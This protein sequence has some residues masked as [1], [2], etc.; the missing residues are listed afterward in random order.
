[1][2]PAL[3]LV[4][5]QP[6]PVVCNPSMPFSTTNLRKWFA[7]AA[8]VIVLTIIVFYISARMQVRQAVRDVPE[9]L[10]VHVEQTTTGFS[11]SKTEAGRTLFT[12]HASNAVQFQEAARAQQRE[13]TIALYARQSN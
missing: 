1:M 2:P 13:V 8:G 10:G 4:G 3:V 5:S 12:I 7:V 11:L 6:P 9:R